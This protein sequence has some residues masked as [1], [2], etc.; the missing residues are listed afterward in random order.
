MIKDSHMLKYYGHTGTIIDNVDNLSIK[1][2]IDVLLI[3]F[4]LSS[5]PNYFLT[6]W[7][8]HKHCTWLRKGNTPVVPIRTVA[9]NNSTRSVPYSLSQ[10]EPVSKSDMDDIVIIELAPNTVRS[11]QDC[12]TLEFKCTT[13]KKLQVSVRYFQFQFTLKNPCPSMLMLS[14][15]QS[16][17]STRKDFFLQISN[18]P[19]TQWNLGHTIHVPRT[20]SK[21]PHH[22]LPSILH[23]CLLRPRILSFGGLSFHSVIRNCTRYLVEFHNYVAYLTHNWTCKAI[24]RQKFPF[25][26]FSEESSECH[27]KDDEND[28]MQNTL[29]FYCYSHG[30]SS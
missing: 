10:P 19:S 22:Q 1:S 6:W 24:G 26:S 4:P 12:C 13:A 14:F 11:P 5:H 16:F 18:S 27:R 9:H 25:I 17:L 2:K 28:Q 7:S 23:L 15:I 3:N 20:H 21:L 8:V 30:T 29:W